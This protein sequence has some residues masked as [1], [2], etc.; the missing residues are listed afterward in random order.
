[1]GSDAVEYLHHIFAFEVLA[2]VDGQTQ[3]GCLA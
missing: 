1:L 3:G 2:N